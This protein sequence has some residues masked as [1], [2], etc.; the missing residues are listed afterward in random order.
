MSIISKIQENNTRLSTLKSGLAADLET[1]GIDV[2]EEEPT[3]ADLLGYVPELAWPYDDADALAAL[4]TQA[5]LIG[6]LEEPEEPE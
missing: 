6:E 4:Q 2:T 1:I 5:E 3:L